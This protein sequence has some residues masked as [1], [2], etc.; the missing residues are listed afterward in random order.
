M[1]SLAV[2]TDTISRHHGGNRDD[3]SRPSDNMDNAL[4][5]VDYN[6]DDMYNFNVAR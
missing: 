2:A 5:S 4:P 1:A 6:K 3:T